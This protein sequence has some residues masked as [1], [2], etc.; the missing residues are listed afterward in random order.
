MNHF[1]FSDYFIHSYLRIRHV[2]R[3]KNLIDYINDKNDKN[4]LS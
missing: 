4:V 3:L 1:L 2:N